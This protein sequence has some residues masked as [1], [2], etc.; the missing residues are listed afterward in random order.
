MEEVLKL[1]RIACVHTATSNIPICDHAAGSLAVLLHEVRA[2]WLNQA[3]ETGLT[4]DLLSCVATELEEIATEADAVVLTCSTLGVAV[5]NVST[6]VPVLRADRSL[7]R[8]AAGRPGRLAILCAAPATIASTTKLFEEEAR[9]GV[10]F[11]IQL[12]EHAWEAFKSGDLEL[13]YNLIA[14][15]PK[16]AFQNGADRVALGQVSMAPAASRIEGPLLTVPALA[17]QAALEEI[18]KSIAH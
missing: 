18:E 3:E 16:K 17:L 8:Q 2:A 1:Y 9:D 4:S 7:A 6:Q 15:A 11:R 10:K 13:Y 5:E 14:E 12:I